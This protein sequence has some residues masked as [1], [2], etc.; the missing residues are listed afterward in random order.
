MSVWS[1]LRGFFGA[2]K[3]HAPRSDPLAGA[4]EEALA[5]V[6]WLPSD[7]NPLG[8]DVLDCRSFTQKML[9]FT[10]DPQ[11]IETFMVLRGSTGEQY[12]DC[13]PD[14]SRICDCDLRYPPY[15]SDD[16]EGPIFQATAMEDK[17][18]IY[19]YDSHLYFVRS[20]TGD[21]VY[22]ARIIFYPDW[23]N[24]VAVEGP[25][26]VIESDAS[27]AV[28]VVDYLIR[29]HVGG[30]PIPHPLP[31]HSGR[32]PSELARF[33]FS[34]YGRRALFGTHADTT[35][36]PISSREQPIPSAV[37]RNAADP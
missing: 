37:P 20:W 7:Q 23:A 11:V 33:S 9:S 30:M 12:R 29:S 10:D 2:K 1:I 24:V 13:T 34:E 16:R 35:R 32:D 36:I 25:K 15:E 26:P 5:E 8:V 14:D 18:N 31:R 3:Q 27:Y 19:L 4:L 17:W 28:A 22:R 6:R 21:L